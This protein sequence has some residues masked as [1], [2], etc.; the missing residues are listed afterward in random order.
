MGPDSKDGI[1]EILVLNLPALLVALA[2]AVPIMA[3]SATH[4]K[5]IL[6]VL[7]SLLLLVMIINEAAAFI[8]LKREHAQFFHS[9]FEM[10]LVSALVIVMLVGIVVKSRQS[11]R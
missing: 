8:R 5:T 11:S 4:H 10:L 9:S 7:W 2:S 1:S 6:K 3:M